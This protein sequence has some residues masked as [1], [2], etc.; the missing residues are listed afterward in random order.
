MM[1]IKIYDENEM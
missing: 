1:S